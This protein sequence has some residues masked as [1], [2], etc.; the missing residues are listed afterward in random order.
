MM[1]LRLL[2]LLAAASL[3]T[4]HTVITY[5]GWR[6][7]NLKTTGDI[8]T[9][10][11]LGAAFDISKGHN[12]SGLLYPY[13]MQWMYP[14]GGMPISHNRTK[15]PLGG[16]ALSFQ[17]AWFPGHSTAFIYVNIG[18]G[19]V[20]ENYSNVLVPPFQLNGPTNERYPGTFCLMRV[21]LPSDL[22]P[23]VGDNA[24]IQLILTAKHGAA[25]YNVSLPVPVLCVFTS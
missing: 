5:P 9:L 25:L 7:D 12:S 21:P 17:P 4:A 19:S 24:T 22:K 1:M 11:G 8:T 14:C 3:A 20:P 16:G 6:G 18:L 2:F 10:D 15:W 13:G 23:K